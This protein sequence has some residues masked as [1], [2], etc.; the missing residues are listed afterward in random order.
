MIIEKSKRFLFI[1]LVLFA[2]FISLILPVSAAE[3]KLPGYPSYDE[4][5][6]PYCMTWYK[7]GSSGYTTVKYIIS[8]SP[9]TV[10]DLTDIQTGKTVY[11]DTSSD[12]TYKTAWIK[13]NNKGAV[14]DNRY[15]NFT[16]TTNPTKDLEYVVTS[17][18]INGKFVGGISS[19]NHDIKIT[20]KNDIVFRVPPVQAVVAGLGEELL[21][22]LMIIVGSTIFLLG[23][24]IS[25]RQL[26]KRLKDY[27]H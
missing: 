25:L 7:V 12:A 17:D 11:F 1:F 13:I 8:S 18:L 16:G 26:P 15:Y 9:I 3:V 4:K 27:F 19:A 6:Y 2:S 14:D 21:K 20:G 10:S 23:L 24:V 22:Y 5:Q